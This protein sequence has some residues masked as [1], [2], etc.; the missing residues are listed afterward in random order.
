MNTVTHK[1]EMQK[2]TRGMRKMASW[3]VLLFNGTEIGGHW[4]IFADIGR[5]CVML[6]Q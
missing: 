6:Q 2:F 5:I 3:L 4:R 1:G